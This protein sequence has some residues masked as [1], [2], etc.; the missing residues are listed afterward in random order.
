MNS[1]GMQITKTHLR[2]TIWRTIY[3]RSL[4]RCMICFWCT[5]AP[6]ASIRPTKNHAPESPVLSALIFFIYPVKHK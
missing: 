3:G 6:R 4:T 2:Y 1:Y 5:S